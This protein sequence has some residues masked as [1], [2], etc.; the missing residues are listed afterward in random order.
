MLTKHVV[1]SQLFNKWRYLGVYFCQGRKSTKRNHGGAQ[2]SLNGEG[3]GTSGLLCR[4]SLPFHSCKDTVRYCYSLPLNLEK[5][6][7]HTGQLPT[8]SGRREE[9]VSLNPSDRMDWWFW[10][11]GSALGCSG[12]PISQRVL[13]VRKA[14]FYRVT[15]KATLSFHSIKS[16]PASHPLI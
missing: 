8:A 15:K 5:T 4:N 13:G 9:E 7:A 3:F 1:W 14:W 2:G 16:T 11:P 12:G 10:V 6:E